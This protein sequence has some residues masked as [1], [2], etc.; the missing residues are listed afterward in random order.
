MR[1]DGHFSQPFY[2]TFTAAAAEDNLTF[3]WKD[4]TVERATD[5]ALACSR[6]RHMFDDLGEEKVLRVLSSYSICLKTTRKK[7]PI[8]YYSCET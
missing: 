8:N 5:L 2:S 4:G 1:R 6:E 7:V 3:D